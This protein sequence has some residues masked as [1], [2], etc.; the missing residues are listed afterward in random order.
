M[1]FSWTGEVMSRVDK[2]YSRMCRYIENKFFE[3][4]CDTSLMDFDAKVNFCPILM[5]ENRLP[6]FPARSK[7]DKKG[8]V[9]LLQ[10]TA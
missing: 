6:H 7:L 9:F 1:E 2:K 4:Q 8:R 5:D 10:P 3:L